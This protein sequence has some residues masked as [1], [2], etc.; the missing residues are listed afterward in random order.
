MGLLMWLG[1]LRVNPAMQVVFVR[2][3][4]CLDGRERDLCHLLRSTNVTVLIVILD[5]GLE[6]LTS[7][8]YALMSAPLNGHGPAD[9]AGCLAVMYLG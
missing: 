8:C 3:I 9:V 5:T 7:A 6:E 2:Q 1:A 4:P